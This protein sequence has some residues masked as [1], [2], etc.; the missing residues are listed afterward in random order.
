M[1]TQLGY[2]ESVWSM[3][4]KQVSA[5]AKLFSRRDVVNRFVKFQILDHPDIP[6]SA[7]QSLA[8]MFDKLCPTFVKHRWK[9]SFE[10]LYWLSSRQAFFK[11]LQPNI[12]K[13]D[14]DS[15]MTKDE[16]DALKQLLSDDLQSARFWAMAYSELV[17]H[18]WGFQ[19]SEWLHSCS[20]HSKEEKKKMQQPCVWNGRRLIEVTGGK[21][22]KFYK[23]LLNLRLESNSAASKSMSELRRQDPETAS[24]VTIGFATAKQKVALRFKQ[25]TSYLETYPWNL[26]NVLSFLC[27]TDD[28]VNRFTSSK[29][30]AASLLQQY[31]DGSLLSIGQFSRFLDRATPLGQDMRDWA[32]SDS[33]IMSL[34]LYQEL[35]GYATTLLCMQRL[36]A[37]HHLVSQRMSTARGSTPAT[38]SANLRR[39]LNLDVHSADFRNNFPRYMLEF[40]KLV[41]LPWQSRAEL[42]RII[43]GYHL[44]IMF[45]NLT[46]EQ[47]LV[48]QTA[49]ARGQANVQCLRDEL[50]HM[51]SVLEEGCFYSVPV[52]VA[53]NGDTT[54]TVLQLLSLQPS[55]KKYTQRVMKV[56]DPW[57]Q[58]ISTMLLGQVVVRNTEA[59]DLLVIEDSPMPLA[60]TDGSEDFSFD[61][62]CQGQAEFEPSVFFKFGFNH[63]YQFDD[64]DYVTAFVCPAD[65]DSA[66][67]ETA[68]VDLK[69]QKH[70]Q[71]MMFFSFIKHCFFG[72]L[73]VFN[74]TS[75]VSDCQEECG[76]PW[77][78]GCFNFK[79]SGCSTSL[80]ICCFVAAVE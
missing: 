62:V 70:G 32:S 30:F 59:E 45:A 7:K 2:D 65:V 76:S 55:L 39:A 57:H 5:L 63:V 69:L 3:Y 14:H 9:Y 77:C 23:D 73:R 66:D 11:Y 58:K 10:V 56:D 12:L 47:A 1:E 31:D 38:I 79:T 26:V 25:A 42:G 36:E 53:S 51:K 34:N 48:N 35:L 20:C 75:H 78:H 19:V 17:L 71:N 46:A 33:P 13:S 24:K 54:Y 4:E 49:T 18:T 60:L 68:L 40:H 6:A 15:D 61:N 28:D 22:S 27:K 67:S 74:Y 43:S 29:A 44:H 52:A 21:L 50:N 8:S 37:K 41:D 80:E 16:C 72:R 64:V